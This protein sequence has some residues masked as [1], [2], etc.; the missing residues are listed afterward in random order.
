MLYTLRIRWVSVP[1]L[2][3]WVDTELQRKE[4]YHSVREQGD[5]PGHLCS[6][7]GKLNTDVKKWGRLERGHAGSTPGCEKVFLVE[8]MEPQSP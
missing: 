5:S 3:Q 8:H 7:P 2:T 4:G 1:L 6:S